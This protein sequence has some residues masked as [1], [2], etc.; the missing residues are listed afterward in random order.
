MN[1]LVKSNGH[2]LDLEARKRRVKAV[3][4]PPSMIAALFQIRDKKVTVDGWPEG[5]EVVGHGM[6]PDGNFFLMLYHPE[7]PFLLDG[8]APSV[9]KIDVHIRELPEEEGA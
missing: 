8:V 5:A 7:F 6:A 9:V 4:V 3:L 2:I 1:Q